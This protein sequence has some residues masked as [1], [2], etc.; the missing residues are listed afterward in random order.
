MTN[1]R[2]FIERLYKVHKILWP[3]IRVFLFLVFLATLAI[4]SAPRLAPGIVVLGLM[5]WISV[6]IVEMLIEFL[7]TTDWG[8]SK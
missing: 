1:P 7:L 6:A 5:S 3:R 8:N 4:R 2:G